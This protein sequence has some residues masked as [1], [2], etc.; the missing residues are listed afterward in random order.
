MVGGFCAGV[1][2]LRACLRAWE[3]I[4]NRYVQKSA[5]MRNVPQERVNDNPETM[6]TASRDTGHLQPTVGVCHRTDPSWQTYGER[7]NGDCVATANTCDR[8]TE[9][10][11]FFSTPARGHEAPARRVRGA[12]SWREAQH[13]SGGE[14]DRDRDR[15]MPTVK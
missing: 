8:E 15:Q 14:S 6:A 10:H 5:P 7:L 12:T 13:V 3:W 2:V 4:T 9:T 1:F 11:A